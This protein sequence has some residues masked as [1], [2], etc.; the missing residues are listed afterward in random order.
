[1][2]SR[3]RHQPSVREEHRD[4]SRPDGCSRNV[5]DVAGVVRGVHRQRFLHV[6]S[7]RRLLWGHLL[8]RL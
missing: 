1:M 8:A 5:V 4:D 2:G 6:T 7:R 3:A